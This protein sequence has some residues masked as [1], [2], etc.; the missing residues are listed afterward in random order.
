MLFSKKHTEKC[1]QKHMVKYERKGQIHCE[2]QKLVLKE[3]CSK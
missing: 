1:E 2:W 3:L